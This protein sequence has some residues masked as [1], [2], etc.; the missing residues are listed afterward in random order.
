MK[1]SE[2]IDALRREGALFADA[3]ATTDPDA[4]VPTCPDWQLRDLV[5][6]T[7]Q[8]HRWATA[9]VAHGHQ[10]PLDEAA[11]EAAWGPVPADA[12]L[13]GWFREGHAGLLEALENAP[14]EL[15]CWAFLP[16]PSPLAFWARRQAHET[17]V[18]RVD[19]EAAAGRATSPTDGAFAL[20]GIGELV[21]GFL[22]GP[23]ARL[24]SAQERT[25]LIRP[26]DGAEPWLVRISQEP[27]RV[28]RGTAPADCEVDGTAHQL[29]LLLWNRLPL[30]RVEVSGDRTLFDL[31]RETAQ[32]R[33]S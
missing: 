31:W 32:I 9:Y 33:W 22:V 23:L 18:H 25:L 8:V 30:T 6:H 24:R 19:A 16:A 11:Q 12:A 27:V 13:V 21:D 5:R 10:G 20:D 1:I 15:D 29:Y 28:E 4:P 17:A 7:G 26:T 3:I 14:A 2:H